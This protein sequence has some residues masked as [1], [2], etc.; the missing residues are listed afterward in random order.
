[1]KRDFVSRDECFQMDPGSRLGT[2]ANEKTTPSDVVTDVV[3]TTMSPM[4]KSERESV[5]QNETKQ[6]NGNQY[7]FRVFVMFVPCV[8]SVGALYTLTWI[9]AVVIDIVMLMPSFG[10]ASCLIMGF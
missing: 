7:P 1:M 2:C 8:G 5:L 10:N 3:P 9:L 4:P 6:Q